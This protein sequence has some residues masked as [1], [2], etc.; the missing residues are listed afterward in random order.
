[1]NRNS[2]LCWNDRQGLLN[3]ILRRECVY[4]FALICNEHFIEKIKESA[5]NII[6]FIAIRLCLLLNEVSQE[7]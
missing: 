6:Y 1:M 7:F 4:T 5:R 2:G 3:S